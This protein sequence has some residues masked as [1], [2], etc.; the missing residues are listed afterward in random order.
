MVRGRGYIKSLDDIGN[1]V[2]MS[3]PQ[4]GTP[5]LVKDLATVTFGPD[6]RR[7]V[8]ELDGQGEAVGG[9]VIMRFG[10]D[11]QKVIERVKQRITDIEP[12]LPKGLKIVNTYDRSD[13]IDRSVDNL[14]HTLIEELV[15]VSLVIM[16]FLWHFPS[17]IIPIITIPI[18]VILAFIPIQMSGMSANIMSLGGIAIAVGAM[19]DAAVVV[20]E[21]THKKLEHWNAEGRPGD[22]H[23]VVISAV[24]EVGGASFFALLVIAVAFLP[25]FTLE[26]QE[27]RLFK[28]LAFTK[29]FAMASRGCWLSRSIPPC[30]CCS[31]AWISSS[32]VRAGWQG[33]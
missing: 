23:E 29:T 16:I 32:S 17:A 28:P 22:Y 15:I 10:E 21:Q 30:A 33:S 9:V 31:P 12:T 5:V 18:T 3:N 7:G 6:M 14:K 19:I 11:A 1:I 4:T 25:V 20:V 13:L 2:V 8:G 26:A 24:K 27:G